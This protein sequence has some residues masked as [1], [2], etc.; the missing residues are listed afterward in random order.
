MTSN[1]DSTKFADEFCKEIM[2]KIK[3]IMDSELDLQSNIID[4]FAAILSSLATGDSFSEWQ[5]RERERQLQKSVGQLVGSLHEIAIGCFENWTRPGKPNPDNVSSS[6]RKL[7]EAKNRYFTVSAGDLSKKFDDLRRHLDTPRYNGFIAY[8]VTIIPDK[9]KST[10]FRNLTYNEE[11]NIPGRDPR[12]DIRVIDG[13]SFYSMISG[14]PEFIDKLFM[15][16]IPNAIK[17]CEQFGE[18]VANIDDFLSVFYD[19]YYRDFKDLS[20]KELKQLYDELPIEFVEEFEEE[21]FK[22]P[23]NSYLLFS[24]DMRKDSTP[25]IAS[26]LGVLW[27]ECKAENREESYKDRAETIKNNRLEQLERFRDKLAQEYSSYR[28][29]ISQNLTSE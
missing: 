1:F 17:E 21:I 19:G 9:N 6:E 23:P 4:P 11:W 13:K 28:E 27:S 26:Q 24:S 16:H 20:P 15:E 29:Y 8:Y 22:K 5:V 25:H 2:L 3:E 14:D 18:T 7:I 10:R 12:D